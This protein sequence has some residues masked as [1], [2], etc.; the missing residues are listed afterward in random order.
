MA[1]ATAVTLPMGGTGGID[2]LS[3]AVSLSSELL[4]LLLGIWEGSLGTGCLISTEAAEA[5][6]AFSDSFEKM[7]V[8]LKR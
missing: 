4:L 3:D 6:V 7:L 2:F 1:T 5:V 8:L